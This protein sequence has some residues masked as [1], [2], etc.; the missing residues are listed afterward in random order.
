MNSVKAIRKDGEMTAQDLIGK[1]IEIPVHYDLW[2]QGARFGK[3]T[4]FRHGEAG[5]SDYVLVKMDYPQ[6]KRSLKLWKLD[7]DYAKV[8]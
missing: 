4:A 3:V 2:R 1:R 8:V 5:Q 6:V 7:W